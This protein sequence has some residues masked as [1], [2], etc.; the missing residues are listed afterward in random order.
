M[1]MKKDRDLEEQSVFFSGKRTGDVVVLS[2]KENLLNHGTHLD[3][4]DLLLDYL[5]FLSK[6][7]AVKVV[8]IMGSPRKIGRE[9]Y[10]KF[11]CQLLE[12]GFSQRDIERLCHAVNQLV[13]KIVGF[14]KMVIHADSGR[15]I[16]LY[17]NISLACDYRIIGDNSVF[18]NPYFDL[19]LV[20][21]GGGAFFLS[22]MLGSGKASEILLSGEDITAEEARR[23][24]IVNE[25][26]PSDEL[27]EA[28]L[29]VAQ[30]FARKPVHS[31]IGIK[32]LLNCCTMDLQS[33]LECENEMLF[34]IINDHDF[35]KRLREYREG[36]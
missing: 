16:S 27:N 2:F 1:N 29:K 15:V 22:R 3:S 7:D 35:R 9:E 20:P 33:C 18:Q 23:L 4:R 34:R 12:P 6:S 32:R 21:K 30:G 10:T 26:V 36:H 14:D 5:E 25:V 8:L 17:M 24:G 31:M 19:G 13:L 11:F 28:A